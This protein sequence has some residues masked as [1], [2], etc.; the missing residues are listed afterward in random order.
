MTDYCSEIAT[1]FGEGYRVPRATPDTDRNER[2]RIELMH[3]GIH[4]R[5]RELQERAAKD[6][7]AINGWRYTERRFSVKTLARGGVHAVRGE[8]PYL[9]DPFELLDHDV[10]FRETSRPY[11]PVAVVG[12]PYDTSVDEGVKIARSLGLELHAPPNFV[13]SWWYP[14]HARF[15]C[16]TRPG[17]VVRFLPDQLTLESRAS[18]PSESNQTEEHAP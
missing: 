8:D 1:L 11:R 18:R 6:F 15:F 2:R 5:M 9:I 10:F 14:G 4:R 3:V 7:A 13:A 12:Q 17:V 16:L